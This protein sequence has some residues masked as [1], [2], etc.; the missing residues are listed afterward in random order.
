MVK[1]VEVRSQVENPHHGDLE[2]LLPGDQ[3]GGHLGSSVSAEEHCGE[4]MEVAEE[5]CGE[6]MAV[7]VVV[8]WGVAVI[9]GRV[10]GHLALLHLVEE[11]R[12]PWG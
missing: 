10:R 8:R 6:E 4:E 9:G 1:A 11:G 7:A 12:S 5:Y 3:V 2:G